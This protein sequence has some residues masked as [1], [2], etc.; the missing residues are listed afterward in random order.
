MPEDLFKTEPGWVAGCT[1]PSEKQWN[2]VEWANSGI[3]PNLALNPGS[4]INRQGHLAQV[5]CVL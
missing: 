2:R 5:P 1:D 4:I 3:R